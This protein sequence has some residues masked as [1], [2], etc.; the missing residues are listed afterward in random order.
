MTAKPKGRPLRC[1][2]CKA[3]GTALRIP[4]AGNT[5]PYCGRHG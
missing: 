3:G 1:A 5:R 2:K 4:G